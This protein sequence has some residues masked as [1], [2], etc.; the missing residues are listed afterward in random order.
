MPPCLTNP[1]V[2]D[3]GRSENASIPLR[4]PNATPNRSSSSVK[5]NSANSVNEKQASSMGH[6]QGIHIRPQLREVTK[7]DDSE[8]GTSKNEIQSAQEQC[9]SNTFDDLSDIATLNSRCQQTACIARRTAT[10]SLPS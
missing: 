5:Q 9:H 4:S 6:Q 10:I 7:N 2:V 1:M 3:S 8:D